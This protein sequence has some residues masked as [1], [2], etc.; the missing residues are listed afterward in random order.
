MMFIEVLGCA[1]GQGGFL[2]CGNGG[3]WNGGGMEWGRGG[4][5]EG[6]NGGGG[7]ALESVWCQGVEGQRNMD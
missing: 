1:S 4:T 2:G 6:W 5:G 3:G 7:L